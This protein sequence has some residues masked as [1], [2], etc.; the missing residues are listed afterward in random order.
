MPAA[1]SL[2]ESRA[3]PATA[4]RDHPSVPGRNGIASTIPTA[5][6]TSTSRIT[7]RRP[8][9]PDP[10]GP[11]GR[12]ASGR[13]RNELP[14]RRESSPSCLGLHRSRNCPEAGHNRMNRLQQAVVKLRTIEKIRDECA[15]NTWDL[16]AITASSNNCLTTLFYSASHVGSSTYQSQKRPRETVYSGF[17]IRRTVSQSPSERYDWPFG[18]DCASGRGVTV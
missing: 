5:S 16:P 6:T 4:I 1:C 8:N 9:R 17:S 11:R 2:L 3:V 7:R 14:D 15:G 12:R 13:G 10:G 18:G